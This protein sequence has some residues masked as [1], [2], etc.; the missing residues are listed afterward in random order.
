MEGAGQTFGR[1]LL[2]RG[3]P[4]YEQ[5]RLGRVFNARRPDRLPAAVLLA[6]SEDDIVEGIRLAAA[7]GWQV[8]V[9]AGG[10]SWAAWSVRDDT[11]LIDLGNFREMSYDAETDVATCTPAVRGGDELAPFLAERGRFFAG[12]HCPTVG[13]GGFLLQGGMGWNARGWGWAAESVVAI[14]AVTADGRLVRADAA[15]NSDLFWAARG[16]GPSLPAVVTRFHLAT[17]PHPCYVAETVHLYP[18]DVFDEVMTWLHDAHHDISTNVEIVALTMTPPEPIPGHHG[19]VLAVTGVAMVDTAEQAAA[20]LA[21]FGDCPVIDRVLMRVDAAPVGFAELRARQVIAN[22]EAHRYRVDNAWL[23]G[24]AAEVV[25]AMRTA[26][27]DLPT[28]Q[29][30]TIWFSMAPLRQLPD[31]ALSLQTDVY[32][33]AYIVYRDVAHDAEIRRWTDAAMA[34][35]QPVTVGQYLGDSDLTNRQVKFMG[36]EAF[37]RLQTVRAAWDPTE[38]FVTYL[39]TKSSPLNTNHWESP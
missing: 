28:P 34:K 14:D 3:E 17:R 21:P 38:R 31:M 29:S 18:L 36:D 33:A 25:P 2:R 37:A 35:M 1:R 10:H 26:F 30:F 4:G 5:A 23:D 19:F 27:V 22:P 7:S 32:V 39:A 20:A 8:A 12:G 9:R 16:A 15:Q 24:A 6:E 13:L 11:L